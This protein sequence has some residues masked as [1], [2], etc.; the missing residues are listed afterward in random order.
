M[1]TSNAFVSSA[2]LI[3]IPLTAFHLLN[4]LNVLSRGAAV[5]CTCVPGA[6]LCKTLMF[7][8]C[9]PFILNCIGFGALFATTVTSNV[10]TVNPRL[11]VFTGRSAPAACLCA[12]VSVLP[13][14]LGTT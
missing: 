8:D 13:I 2:G 9:T 7:V 3:V 5:I 14:C 4:V 6:S 10:F 12:G 11:F 1:N